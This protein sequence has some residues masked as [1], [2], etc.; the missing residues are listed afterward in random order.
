MRD[1][2]GRDL[3]SFSAHN[4]LKIVDPGILLVESRSCLLF[5]RLIA[6]DSF[7]W[8]NFVTLILQTGK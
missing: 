8:S 7:N 1:S 4:L 2:C 5:Q 6:A 3:R